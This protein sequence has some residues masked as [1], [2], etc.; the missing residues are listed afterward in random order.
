MNKLA[1]TMY[2]L[3]AHAALERLGLLK[4]A[5]VPAH[6]QR[7][8]LNNLERMVGGAPAAVRG[9]DPQAAMRAGALDVLGASSD[10]GQRLSPLAQQQVA[11]LG[12][13]GRMPSVGALPEAMP[14]KSPLLR[15]QGEGTLRRLEALSP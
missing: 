4:L 7:M 5:A 14:G 10:L 8:V 11:T 13:L 15:A 3:G 2:Q 12:T 9:V 6:Q 1:S